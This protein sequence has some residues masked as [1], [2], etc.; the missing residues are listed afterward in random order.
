[1]LTPED[2]TPLIADPA[3][4]LERAIG[5][6]LG[7]LQDVT[8]PALCR[9]TPCADW[10]VRRLLDHVNDSLDALCEGAQSGHIGPPPRS[11]GG[12]E[13]PADVVV[14]FRDRASRLLSGCGTVGGPDRII[15][16]GGLAL[17]VR[18]M[19]GVGAVEVTAHGWDISQA[20]GR[21][22][23]IP[24]ALAT[25]LLA[26]AEVFVP[27][28]G[29]ARLFAEPVAPPAQASPGDRLVAFLGR[30]PGTWSAA[31]QRGVTRP[32]S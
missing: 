7:T 17:P 14:A 22:R 13:A 10:D 18:I 12:D 8:F 4:L 20:C 30:S 2:S 24:P 3:G 21:R 5:Y 29:R 26:V 31:R 23:P 28:A 19:A 6:A 32:G 27:R 9:P 11:D 15:S 1:V 25:D 16:I